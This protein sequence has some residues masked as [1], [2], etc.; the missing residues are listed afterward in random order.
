MDKVMIYVG[1]C[2]KTAAKLN[3]PLMWRKNRYKSQLDG[4]K[5]DKMDFEG[6]LTQVLIVC[7]SLLFQC[8]QWGI[9]ASRNSYYDQSHSNGQDAADLWRKGQL[10]L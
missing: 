6:G 10:K 5:K 9:Y 2:G 8:K 4:Q 1:K 3:S 7:C